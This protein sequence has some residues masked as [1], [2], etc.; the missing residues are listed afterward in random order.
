[1]QSDATLVLLPGLDGTGKLF[2]PLVACLPGPVRYSI[3]GYPPDRTLSID[4]MAGRVADRLPPGPIVLLAES[5]SGLVAL[6]LLDRRFPGLR[7]VIFCAAFAGSPH[8]W[9]LNAARRVPAAGRLLQCLPPA[10]VRPFVFGRHA[11]RALPMLLQRTLGEV[12][13]HVLTHRLRLM[14]DAKPPEKTHFAIPCHYLQAAQDRLV[15]PRAADWFARH[16][17]PFRLQRVDGPHM[18]LQ[19]RPRVCARHISIICQA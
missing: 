17:D 10:V 1:M 8:P 16:F 7:A 3:I 6:A 9:L 19:T 13:P 11:G 4:Q 2:Q 5:F 12:A 18:L 14:A 15:P